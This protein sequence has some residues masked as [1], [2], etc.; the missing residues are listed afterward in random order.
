MNEKI[1]NLVDKYEDDAIKLRHYLHENPE[2][3]SEEF[4]TSKLMKSYAED[5]GLKIEEVPADESS[6]GTGFIA[7]LDTG[8]P[9]KTIGLRTDIDGLPV[10]ENMENL[11]NKR[12]I[13]SKKDGVMHA[14][15]HDGHMSTIIHSMKILNE[16]KEELT[17]KIIFIFEEAEEVGTG[18]DPLI[19]LLKTKNI[20][21]IYGNHLAAFLDTGYITADV[22]P[23]MAAIADVEFTIIG[24]GGHGSRP[25]LS[26]NPLIAGVDIINSLALAWNNQIDVTETVT[27]GFTQFHVGEQKNVFSDKATIGGSIR[28]F[29]IETGEKAYKMTID[30]ARKVADIHNCEIK[31]GKLSGPD[32]DPTINDEK[33]ATMVQSSVNELFP[34]AL[35][36]DLTW[37]ASESFADYSKIAP[38]AFA[39]IGIRNDEL[40]SGAEHH[41]EYFD[42]DDDALKYSIGTMVKF[43]TDY[44]SK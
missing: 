2:L 40:G 38:S 31:V 29:D 41:S 8:K 9:G 22:G 28:Y 14:C 6:S 33:L 13:I 39:F 32:L 18:I 36:H 30:I 42:V 1:L 37:F 17:G 15:G 10:Q 34:T 24:K 5:L 23:V 12:K 21:A 25:D 11:A 19:N 7:T 4:E 16:L 3:S 20:D 44:L 27:F 26:F 43:A 35:K